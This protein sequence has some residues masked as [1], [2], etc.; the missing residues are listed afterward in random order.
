MKKWKATTLQNKNLNVEHCAEVRSRLRT[1]KKGQTMNV[2]MLQ[3]TL[4][5]QLLTLQGRLQPNFIPAVEMK[6]RHTAA[7]NY[8]KASA[9]LFTQSLLRNAT[10]HHWGIEGIDTRCRGLSQQN[11]GHKY[12]EPA[13][14]R[15]REDVFEKFCS[16]RSILCM[17]KSFVHKDVACVKQKVL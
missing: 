10:D 16:C 4:V 2:Q 13:A 1:D 8:N 15:G 14:L 12:L 17:C 6:H 3:Q 9:Q 11:K 7:T 5:I